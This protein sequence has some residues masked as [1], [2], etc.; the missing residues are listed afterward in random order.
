MDYSLNKVCSVYSL[1]KPA[2]LH[3]TLRLSS[4][5]FF[6]LARVGLLL[7]ELLSI[8]FLK[9]FCCW[10]PF[11]ISIGVILSVLTLSIRGNLLL[12]SYLLESFMQ[13]CRLSS[14]LSYVCM[15]WRALQTQQ[16][17]VS[18]TICNILWL[19]SYHCMYWSCKKCSICSTAH[20]LHIRHLY[21]SYN[22]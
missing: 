13:S 10:M 15:L 9:L 18:L 14:L 11:T 6:K 12:E 8:W 22:Y 1:L 21:C 5:I 20:F 19:F 2:N 3:S 7:F 4:L 16:A 17:L